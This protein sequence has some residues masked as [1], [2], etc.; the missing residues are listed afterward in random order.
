MYS[1]F[2]LDLA[3]SPIQLEELGLFL[4]NQAAL[5]LRREH[6][7]RHANIEGFMEFAEVDERTID[8]AGG[9]GAKRVEHVLAELTCTFPGSEDQPQRA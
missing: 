9:K 5:L 8:P 6:G 3:D 7:I 1:D 2:C 4:P